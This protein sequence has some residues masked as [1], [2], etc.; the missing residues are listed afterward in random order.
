MSAKSESGEHIGIWTKIAICSIGYGVY[1][2]NVIIP[3]VTALLRDFPETSLFAQNM[4]LTGASAVSALISAVICGFLVRWIS[5]RKLM[6]VGAIM[7]FIGGVGGFFGKSVDVLIALRTLD[8]FS[9][10]ILLTCVNSLIAQIFTDERERSRM[11]G[12]SFAAASVFGMAVSVASGYLCRIHWNYGYLANALSFISILLV[13]L[14]VPDTPLEKKKNEVSSAVKTEWRP[15]KAIA[16]LVSFTLIAAMTTVPSILMDM[17]INELNIGD[18]ASTGI[19]TMVANLSSLAASVVLFSYVYGKAKKHILPGSVLLCG[20]AMIGLAFSHDL[21][22]FSACMGLMGIVSTFVFLYFQMFLSEIVP[23]YRIGMYMSFYTV[24]QYA[25]QFL[26]PYLPSFVR[27]LDGESA[28][29][30]ATVFL[31]GV[32]LA[33]AGLVLSVAVVQSNRKN[34]LIKIEV[35]LK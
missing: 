35:K 12:L 26:S 31:L 10:G 16:A 22:S 28:N 27:L 15:E 4:Y 1:S 8:G 11:Y 2:E 29:M 7:F 30:S 25:S 3:L 33:G 14:F 17:L 32:I 19:A 20:A 21:L 13:I 24:A 5:K 9:D 6:I 18:S 34:H 23:E